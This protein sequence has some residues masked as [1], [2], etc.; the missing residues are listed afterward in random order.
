[1]SSEFDIDNEENFDEMIFGLD[2]EKELFE[3]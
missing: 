1:M 3:G 2:E